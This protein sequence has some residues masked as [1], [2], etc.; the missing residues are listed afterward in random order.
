MVTDLVL[1]FFFSPGMAGIS[2]LFWFPSQRGVGCLPYGEAGQHFW[3]CGPGSGL[4]S[5][6]WEPGFRMER[7]E[8]ADVGASWKEAGVLIVCTPSLR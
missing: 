5:M 4:W 8:Q 2:C 6:E 3:F 1:C 7:H